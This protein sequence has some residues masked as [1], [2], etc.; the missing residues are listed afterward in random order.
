M[1]KLCFTNMMLIGTEEDII[2]FCDYV[3]EGCPEMPY[4]AGGIRESL[5]RGS[6]GDSDNLR[7][8]N[9]A[10]AVYTLHLDDSVKNY[11]RDCGAE[12]ETGVLSLD[13]AMRKYN[14]VAD[15]YT[16]VVDSCIQE[17][18]HIGEDGKVIYEQKAYYEIPILEY[19]S[20]DEWCE[21]N[22]RLHTILISDED[23]MY[24]YGD[25]KQQEALK[26]CKET[27]DKEGIA[28][29]IDIILEQMFN[30]AQEE[31]ESS[32]IIGGYAF[33]GTLM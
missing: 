1:S 30:E 18:V 15:I 5:Q 8:N 17:Y 10:F 21:A 32:I 4:F 3:L 13:D 16:E 33:W 2:N 6:A 19:D 14:L 20:Y 25:T 31:E 27:D 9:Q 26:E 23:L 29:I 11:I 24:S 22:E 12:L 28:E 7:E